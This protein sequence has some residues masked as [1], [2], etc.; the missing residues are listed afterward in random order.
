MAQRSASR[1]Q[2]SLSLMLLLMSIFALMSAGMFY[3]SRV[4]AV[5]DEIAALSGSAATGSAD[6][7]RTTHLIFLMFTYTSPLLLAM[8]LG[9]VVAVL[10]YRDR[11]VVTVRNN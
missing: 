10:R 5:Q 8:L 1:P 4:G 9:A 3:A 11:R 2:I 6:A 7:S